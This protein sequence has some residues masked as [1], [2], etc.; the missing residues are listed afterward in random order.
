MKSILHE[1]D[2]NKIKMNWNKKP[3]QM[4]L[5]IS[6]LTIPTE[7]SRNHLGSGMG[8]TQR[9]NEE[10]K[11]VIGGGIVN[12]INYLDTI[13]F[14]EKL[15]NPYNNYV[16]PFFLFDIMNEE[17]KKFFIDYYKEDILE[18]KVKAEKAIKHAKLKIEE[19]KKRLLDIKQI[20]L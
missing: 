20:D 15:H 6:F 12:G 8:W 11:L 19:N 17:G 4:D 1:L 2:N 7:I 3:I 16:S 5:F 14:G 13:Q 9:I 18:L 10:L